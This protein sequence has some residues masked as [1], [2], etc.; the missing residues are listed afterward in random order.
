MKRTTSRRQTLPAFRLTVGQAEVLAQELRGL[1]HG[2]VS[3]HFSITLGADEYQFDTADEIRGAATTLP[4]V[5][6]DFSLWVTAWPLDY[7][8]SLSASGHP[9][10]VSVQSPDYGWCAAVIATCERATRQCKRWYSPLRAWHFCVLATAASSVTGTMLGVFKA[11]VVV[12][13]MGTV[14]WLLLTALRWVICVAFNRVF[15]PASLVIR[16]REAWVKRRTPELTLLL[17]LAALVV[18]ILTFVF[19]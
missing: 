5:V 15:P 12:S 1:F 3:S 19:K 9:F 2:E 10:S 16:E 8:V 6:H 17:S 14:A 7:Y 18:A 13:L 11:A 4:A